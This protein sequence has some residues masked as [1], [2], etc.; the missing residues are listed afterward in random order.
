MNRLLLSF[1]LPLLLTSAAMAQD[2]LPHF[3]DYPVSGVYK[4]PNAPVVLKRDDRT[5][6]TRLREASKEKPNFAGHYILTAWGCGT[7]CLMGAVIDAATG[8]VY[9]WDFTICCW[10]FDVDN[11]FQP[12]EFRLNSRLIVFSGARNEKEG[13]VAAH[14]YKFENGRFIHLRSVFKDKQNND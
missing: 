9:W 11:K 1:V 7:S 12:I 14:F 5:F 8:R 10:S 3:K 13:D 4:G 2:R 6:R